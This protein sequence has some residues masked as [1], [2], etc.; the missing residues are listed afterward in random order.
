MQVLSGLVDSV[1]HPVEALERGAT[2]LLRLLSGVHI[3]AGFWAAYGKMSQEILQMLT[4]KEEFSGDIVVT[5]H[6][7]G[8]ALA[9]LLALDLRMSLGAKVAIALYTF[10]SPRVGNRAFA[11]IFNLAV[12]RSF[13][14]VFRNDI[15]T[16]MPGPPFF[17]HGKSKLV[18]YFFSNPSL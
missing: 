11:K 12:P 2:S 17:V 14:V 10:G 5:G 8:G 9:Q 1:M 13:R 3:H 6:S 18:M 7:L 16:T 15:V 4:N